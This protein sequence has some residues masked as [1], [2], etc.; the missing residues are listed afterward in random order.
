VL[1]R[2]WVTVCQGIIEGV[3][4]GDPEPTSGDSILDAMGRVLMPTFVDCHTHAC[5]VGSRLNEFES[6]LAGKT[7]LEILQEGGGIMSTVAAVRDASEEALVEALL[8]HISDMAG[9]GTGTLEV[10]SGYGLSTE[11]ELKMLRAIHTASTE[12]LQHVAG[13]FLGAHAIDPANPDF[14]EQT[15]E[16]TLPAVVSEF[17]GITCDAY[18]EVGAWDVQDVT[19]LLTAAAA[20][21][22]PLRVHTDQFNRLGMVPVA[23]DLGAVTIDHLEAADETDLRLLADSSTIGVLLP[24]SGFCLDDRYAN[25]R[26]LIDMGGAVAI[27]TNSNPGSAP[28]PS[29]PLTIALACRKCGLLPSEAITA[30]TWN[31]ACVLGVEDEVGSLEVGK[32]ACLQVL[33][34]QDERELAWWIGGLGPAMVMIDGEV[35]SFTGDAQAA[36]EGDDDDG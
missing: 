5:W 32:R 20:L 14:I 33:D 9:L 29:M 24:A 28:S 10:K 15:I 21:G 11:A 19:R 7:Y 31:G 13:T 2:G 6:Q 34:A 16:E 1:E 27:A 25:G 36:G 18:C 26:G 23:I 4:S 3:G 30:A 17:P 22:C 8:D 12:T 35:V